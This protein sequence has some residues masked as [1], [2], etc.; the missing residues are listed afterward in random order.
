[1]N[2]YE[3]TVIGER[4][5]LG[6]H[7]F[8][9]DE[10][11]RYAKQFDPQSFHVDETAAAQSHFGKLVASGWHTG[12]V[13][14][15][16]WSEYYQGED[17]LRLARGEQVARVGPSPGFRDLKWLKPVYAGDTIGYATE[18][19]QKRPS[20]SRPEWGLVDMINT[21]VNQSGELVFSFLGTVFIERRRRAA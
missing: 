15:K 2:F 19:T 5:E 6:K 4:I 14:V 7:V 18:L 12:A 21:G 8:T 3:D 16:L 17:Q 13:W 1:M 11:V 9:K 20:L 10:I